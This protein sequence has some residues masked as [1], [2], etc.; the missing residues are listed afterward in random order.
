MA[1]KC[2]ARDTTGPHR[3]STRGTCSVIGLFQIG[4]YR[5]LKADKLPNRWRYGFWHIT[6]RSRKCPAWPLR[7]GKPDHPCDIGKPT[8]HSVRSRGIA[9]L[10]IGVCG[11]GGN[12]LVR[13]KRD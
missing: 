7:K 8:T 10:P 5:H 3:P 2:R 6:R 13:R 9:D 1:R 11:G 4:S 12:I